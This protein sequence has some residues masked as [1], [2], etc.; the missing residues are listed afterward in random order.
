MPHPLLETKVMT[1]MV[2]LFETPPSWFRTN[3]FPAKSTAAWQAEYYVQNASRRITPFQG[4]GR[5]GTMRAKGDRTLMQHTYLHVRPK[6]IVKDVDMQ[7]LRKPGSSDTSEA[8]GRQLVVDTLDDLRR[9]VDNT[10]EWVGAQVL[11]GATVSVTIDGATVTLTTGLT[12]THVTTA[13]AGWAT[14]ATDI[15]GDINTAKDI[16][17][18]DSGLTPDFILVCSSV[19]THMINNTVLQNYFKESSDVNNIIRD[20]RIARLLGLDV[21]VYDEY[22]VPDD[23]TAT[24]IWNAQL[25]LIGCY[26]AKSRSMMLVGPPEDVAMQ[27]MGAGVGSKSWNSEDPPGV[28]V[29]LEANFYPA[30]PIPDAFVVHDVVP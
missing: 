14:A 16:V 22:Y 13:S 28:N 20:G 12:T 6:D 10:F 29:L 18:R 17:A 21:V 11:Q 1:E 4:R 23:G 7:S 2:R 26:A 3:L 9:E 15:V 24:R 25:A 8:Y 5:E 30:L 27:G 19:H